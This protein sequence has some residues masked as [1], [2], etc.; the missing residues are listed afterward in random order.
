MCGGGGGGWKERTHKSKDGRAAGPKNIQTNKRALMCFAA[1]PTVRLPLRPPNGRH[2]IFFQNCIDIYARQRHAIFRHSC[3]FGQL[4]RVL[5]VRR[6]L[7]LIVCGGVHVD[8]SAGLFFFQKK[9]RRGR[10]RWEKKKEED[11]GKRAKRMEHR[12]VPGELPEEILWAIWTWCAPD[13]LVRLTRVSRATCASAAAFVHRR[14]TGGDRDA[15]LDSGGEVIGCLMWW[16]RTVQTLPTDGE[17]RVV[18]VECFDKVQRAAIHA[19]AYRFGCA[20]RR[21]THAGLCPQYRYMCECGQT[22]PLERILWFDRNRVQGDCPGCLEYIVTLDGQRLCEHDFAGDDRRWVTTYNAVMIV[23][24]GSAPFLQMA[25]KTSGYRR[26][27]GRLRWAGKIG[28]LSDERARTDVA[29]A[30]DRWRA[31]LP[32]SVS[33]CMASVGRRRGLRPD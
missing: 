27:G 14:H 26:P 24:D 13:D 12:G 20:S 2:T 11:E 29:Y 15:I 4:P 1:G 8:A 21:T 33:A 18:F 7:L 3:F 22:S 5:Q 10:L 25:C 32:I 31:W 17:A 19:W 30:F 28:R 23:A 16:L 9:K 6:L